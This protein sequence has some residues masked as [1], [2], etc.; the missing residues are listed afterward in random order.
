MSKRTGTSQLYTLNPDGSNLV[1]PIT[2]AGENILPKWNSAGRRIVFVSTRDGGN[3]EIYAMRPGGEDQTRLTN[4]AWEDWD[5]SFA[6]D[7]SRIVFA[8][9]PLDQSNLDLYIMN[10]DG[11]NQQRITVAQGKDA[12]ANWKIQR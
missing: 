12:H 3:L 11:T 6:P 5:P 10:T 1:G 4:N 2:T 7:D 8:A 9:A